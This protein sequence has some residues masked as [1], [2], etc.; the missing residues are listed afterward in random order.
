M[1]R[2]IDF[3]IDEPGRTLCLI[4]FGTF[5]IFQC[6]DAHAIKFNR[7]ETELLN[8]AYH[9]G[10]KIGHPEMLQAIMLN[11]SVAGR[12][13]RHGDKHFKNWKSQCYGVMQI[14]LYTARMVIDTWT[15]YQM[16]DKELRTR[17]QYDDAFNVEIAR[18]Y[19]EYLLT[20]CNDDPFLALLGYNVGP[21]NVIDHG[22]SF[23]PNG[24]LPKAVK[25]IKLLNRFNIVQ[26][27][28]SIVKYTIK[29]GDTLFKIAQCILFNGWRWKEIAGAN[30]EIEP[31]KLKVGSVIYI[32]K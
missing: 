32:R 30:P 10:A 21:G 15:N 9:E 3:L 20:M 22:T 5:L 31:T 17:L 8:L 12:W 24:Y 26:G 7:G 27:N 6:S 14:Q 28:G 4:F 1:K 16:S 18:R 19:Y 23:D 13:G 29:K 11:E 25:Y 2:L